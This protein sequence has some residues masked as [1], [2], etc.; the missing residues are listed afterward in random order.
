M[1]SAPVHQVLHIVC[2]RR[3]AKD[4]G[5]VSE[6]PVH[7]AAMAPTKKKVI[8]T[9]P[10]PAHSEQ[11][12]SARSVS[13]LVSANVNYCKYLLKHDR[14]LFRDTLMFQTRIYQYESLL[15]RFLVLSAARQNHVYYCTTSSKKTSTRRGVEKITTRRLEGGGVVIQKNIKS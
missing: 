5:S 12:D 10:E 8:E 3:T 14:V 15:S 13:L 9:E 6:L 1:C 7:G 11:P 4:G 2:V